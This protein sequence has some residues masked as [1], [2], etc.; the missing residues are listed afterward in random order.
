[1]KTELL[2]KEEEGLFRDYP[3]QFECLS[4]KNRQVFRQKIA[5]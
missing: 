1:M 3:D 2:A 5:L 4:S